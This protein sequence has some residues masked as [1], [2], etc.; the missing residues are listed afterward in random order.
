MFA[1][2]ELL[3]DYSDEEASFKFADFDMDGDLDRVRYD[4][5]EFLGSLAN[6]R[7]IID[8]TFVR[9]AP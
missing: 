3:P 6:G 9:Q 7:L 1:E 8:E 2:C 4:L 5:A